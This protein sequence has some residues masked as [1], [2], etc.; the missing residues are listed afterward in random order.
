MLVAAGALCAQPVVALEHGPGRGVSG[1]QIFAQQ[2]QQQPSWRGP[3]IPPQG[4][5]K[6]PQKHPHIGQWLKK[7]Q[8]LSLADQEKALT[9]DPDFQNL[10]QDKQDHLKERLREF[11]NLPPD[12]RQRILQRMDAFEHLTP[13]QQDQARQIFTRV[14]QMPDEQR[15]HFREGM[16]QLAD[17]KPEQRQNLVDSSDLRSRYTDEERGLMKQFVN[18]NV[19]PD[20]N[21]PEPPP[22]GPPPQ[23]R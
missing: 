7:H 22:A 3:G 21:E 15:K 14:R 10:P 8:G 1:I 13:E 23:P 2:Q 6:G 9:S 12:Q 19:L 11:N 20:R 5:R 17:A 18:L 4:A 16:R